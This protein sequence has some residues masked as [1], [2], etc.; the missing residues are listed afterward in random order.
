[1]PDRLGHLAV[2]SHLAQCEQ[3]AARVA[4]ERSIV[5][6]AEELIAS[7][8]D[9]RARWSF[10]GADPFAVFRG[11]DYAS[12]RALWRRLAAQTQ[13]SDPAPTIVPFTG[14]MVGYWAYDFGRRLE[15]LPAQARDDLGLPEVLLAFY[16]VVGAFDHRTRQAWLFS[17]GLPLDDALRVTRAQQRL[18]QFSRLITAG[19]RGWSG[20]RRRAPLLPVSTFEPAEYRRA[21]ERIREARL[22]TGV[23]AE[24][25]ES[26]RR[27]LDRPFR[28]P[29]CAGGSGAGE[30]GVIARSAATR[31]SS[32]IAS[33]RSQ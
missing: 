6:G 18:D 24:G 20:F 4:E 16:D 2:E 22:R 21:V 23:G 19:R 27:H 33:L 13:A 9:D 1:M 12:A 8:D 28:Q 31:Q 14:G 15:R 29:A 32:W 3:C 17:S 10:F 5:S 11:D 25:S 7:L 30:I 26:A